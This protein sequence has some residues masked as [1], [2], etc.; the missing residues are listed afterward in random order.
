MS[1]E[2][3]I[4]KLLL[5]SLSVVSL[6]AVAQGSLNPPGLGQSSTYYMDSMGIPAGSAQTNGSTTTFTDARGVP[7]GSAQRI[8]DTVYFNDAMGIPVGRA[9]T[10]RGTTYF[11]GANGVPA[12]SA[13]S[14][15]SPSLSR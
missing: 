2:E 4:M 15:W 1:T 8:G 11:T 10:I 7:A 6:N 14:N 9:E 12:G 13:S 5:L 3:V